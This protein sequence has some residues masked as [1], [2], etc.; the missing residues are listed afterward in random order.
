MINRVRLINVEPCREDRTITGKDYGRG[1]RISEGQGVPGR[2]RAVTRG[3]AV[4]VIG[5]AREEDGPPTRRFAGVDG[6][7]DRHGVVGHAVAFG[8]ERLDVE[9]LTSVGQ[10]GVACDVTYD[11]H[12]QQT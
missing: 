7:L 2:S 5:A 12:P 4:Q 9:D 8:P 1:R 3:V 6:R 10:R 11:R